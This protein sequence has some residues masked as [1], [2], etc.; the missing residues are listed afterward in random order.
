MIDRDRV[1]KLKRMSEGTGDTCSIASIN[2]I[3]A[4][5]FYKDFSASKRTLHLQRALDALRKAKE[6]HQSQN[7]YSNPERVLLHSVSTIVPQ[8]RDRLGVASSKT[9]AVETANELTFVDSED[10]SDD[11][12]DE[13]VISTVNSLHASDSNSYSPHTPPDIW[14]D[15]PYISGETI[16]E[17]LHE[18]GPV[19]GRLRFSPIQQSQSQLD[20]PLIEVQVADDMLDIGGIHTIHIDD[21][22]IF[23][24]Q[25]S[26][27]NL[28]HDSG[29]SVTRSAPQ[30]Q[31]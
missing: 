6:Q 9:Q 4:S 1:I 24:R 20:Y 7:N 13:L 10:E 28:T 5:T 30:T 25:E 11:L 19:N 29:L 22:D 3:P 16:M 23:T 21:S 17:S 18:K 12:A 14:D 31:D 26:F 15:T 2:Y 8:I 27:R